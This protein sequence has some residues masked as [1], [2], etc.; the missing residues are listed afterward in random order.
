MNDYVAKIKHEN[1]NSIS[2]CFYIEQ[3]KIL[4]IG[5]KMNELDEN[6]YMNGY[7]WG[8]FLNRY[9]EVNHPDILQEMESDPEA[10]MYVAYYKATPEN[11]KK[12]D[13]LLNVIKDFVE[14]ESKIYDFVKTESEHIE[15][16]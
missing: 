6:A 3:D 13:H 16:D 2:V 11:E 10:G 5:D 8:A 4:A 7:N 14:N 12:A 9:L 1:S 15:W